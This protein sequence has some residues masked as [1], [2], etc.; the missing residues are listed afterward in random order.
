M[1]FFIASA[2][3]NPAAGQPQGAA[4]WDLIF[5]LVIFGLIFYF[6]IY[7]PQAKRV[8][9]HKALMSSIGKGDEVLTQGG[10]LGRVAKVADDKDYVVIEVADNTQVMVQKSAISAVLPKGTL[11]SL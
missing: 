2:H 11:K 7:R 6:M 9:E 3:A 5:M 8:K 1:D 4:G 10:L